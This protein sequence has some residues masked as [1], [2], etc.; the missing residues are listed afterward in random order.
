MA[1][2]KPVIKTKCVANCHTGENE[3]IAEFSTPIGGGL[4]SVRYLPA[5]NQVIVDVYRTDATVE[6]RGVRP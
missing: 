3:T 5:H 1:R 6:V 2:Q 4:I